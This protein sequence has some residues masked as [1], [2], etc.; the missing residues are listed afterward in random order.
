[1]TA[2]LNLIGTLR[3][4]IDM[5]DDQI[6]Q[7]IE[8]RTQLASAIGSRKRSKSSQ[9]LVFR[10][11]R[12]R[13]ILSR[14]RAKTRV[15]G[16]VVDAIW[17]EIMGYALQQQVRTELVLHG[18]GNRALLELR[19]RALFGAAPPITWTDSLDEALRRAQTSETLAIIAQ[20]IS[21]LDPMLRHCDTIRAEDGSAIAWVIGR[22]AEQDCMPSGT[23]PEPAAAC[24]GSDSWSPSGWRHKP[25]EQLPAYPD[26]TLL[27]QVERRLSRAAPLVAIPDILLLRASLSQV[28][29]GN[30]FLLQGGDCAESFAEFSADKIRS[31]YRLL[32]E[33]GAA[34]RAAGETN[35][36]HLARIAGQFAKPRSSDV[37]M[38]GGVSLPS[39]RGDAVNGAAPDQQSRTP[40]PRRLLNAHRQAR[41]TVDLLRAFAAASYADLPQIG[42]AAGIASASRPVAM[43][44]S[45]EALLLNYEQAL[46]QFD[47]ATES[48]WTTSGH[49]IWIGDRTRGLDGAHVEFARGVANPIGLKCGPTLDRDT[50][51]H[52]IDRLDPHNSPGRLVLIGRFGA[53]RIA[54]HLPALLRAC[55]Q[56]GRQVIWSIDPMHG[57]TQ[58]VGRYKTRRLDH[59]QDEIR[60]F[61]EICEAEDLHPGGVHLEMTGSPVTECLG[62]SIAVQ[63][64]DLPRRYLTHC[65]PRLNADQ[66]RDVAAQLSK[67][68]EGRV[69]AMR[70]AA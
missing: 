29:L 15:S 56:E 5:V 66:A 3:A 68:L 62:G 37:E 61:F 14:L 23:G 11:R 25:A 45:H 39:Y 43:Y 1:M 46:C 54:R 49:M 67:L 17:R 2:E 24:G 28:A 47:E 52:L 6:L 69:E 51:L 13:E 59:I 9:S 53:E 7:L 48:W 8:R 18:I 44:T 57:N 70:G 58:T 42:Q 19:V 64:E 30:S 20:P 55:R 27:A 4:E 10:P 34:L 65:D 33:M 60:S 12:Q 26:P 36:V 32:L 63:E 21:D 50:L 22:V 31:T 41:A 38:I 40:D 35:V 16:E